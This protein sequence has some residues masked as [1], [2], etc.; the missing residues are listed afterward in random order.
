M[1]LCS[2]ITAA[3]YLHIYQEEN[4]VHSTLTAFH[5][6]QR[7]VLTFSILQMLKTLSLMR[8]INGTLIKSDLFFVFVSSKLCTFK[9]AEAHSVRSEKNHQNI[10]IN[11]VTKMKYKGHNS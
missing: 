6:L 8:E 3:A 7:L 10:Y 9:N 5:H 4:T 1:F 11:N 2:Q